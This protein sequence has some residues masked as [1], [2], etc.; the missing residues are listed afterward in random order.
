MELSGPI[1][2]HPTVQLILA[3]PL[4]SFSYLLKCKATFHIVPQNTMGNF[5]KIRYAQ[6]TKLN[7]TF[8]RC[9]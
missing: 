1:V 5:L 3:G 7:F 8:M 9:L 2:F 4:L 6:T